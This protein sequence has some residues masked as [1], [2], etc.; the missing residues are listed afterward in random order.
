MLQCS[1]EHIF[2]AAASGDRHAQSNIAD[3]RQKMPASRHRRR[4]D[5][6]LQ[7]TIGDA[8]HRGVMPMTQ[9]PLGDDDAARALPDARQDERF[10]LSICLLDFSPQM[11]RHILSA[12]AKQTYAITF[13]AVI[14]RLGY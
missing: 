3:S 2:I 13:A 1:N 9:L 7:D 4:F 11:R 14:F 6:R 5:T 12:D 10:A 8:A